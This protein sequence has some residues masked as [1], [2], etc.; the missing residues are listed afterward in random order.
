MFILASY[1]CNSTLFNLVFFKFSQNQVLTDLKQH[2]FSALCLN[3]RGLEAFVNHNP[4]DRLFKVMLGPNYLLA[5]RT[6]RG[7]SPVGKSPRI[8]YIYPYCWQLGLTLQNYRCLVTSRLLTELKLNFGV[9]L[10][11]YN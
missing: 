6:R 9:L 11:L 2:I 7:S 1:V 10:Q 3:S 8:H 5:M 4:F